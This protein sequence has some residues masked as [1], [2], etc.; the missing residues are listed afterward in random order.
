M[1]YYTTHGNI[2]VCVC[3]CVSE[4][5]RGGGEEEGGGGGQGEREIQFDKI[6]LVHPRTDHGDP[7]G[8]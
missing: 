7:E 3:V 5:E 2:C 1:V 4:S 6:E 8:E